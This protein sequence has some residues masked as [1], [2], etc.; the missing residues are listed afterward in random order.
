MEFTSA[1]LQFCERRVMVST[2]T[3]VNRSNGLILCSVFRAQKRFTRKGRV[4]A[5]GAQ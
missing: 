5:Q 4:I 2:I 1:L 3:N